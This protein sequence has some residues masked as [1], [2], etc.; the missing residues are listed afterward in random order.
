MDTWDYVFDVIPLEET[1]YIVNY[2]VSSAKLMFMLNIL[3]N[4]QFGMGVTKVFLT[5]LVKLRVLLMCW[6]ST[7]QVVEDEKTSDWW[8][9]YLD[10]WMNTHLM[11]RL[12]YIKCELEVLHW[13]E[14]WVLKNISENTHT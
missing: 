4:L 13:M 11:E 6:V 3:D 8:G 12:L 5:M 14:K 7:V 10:E 2:N 1:I 9:A